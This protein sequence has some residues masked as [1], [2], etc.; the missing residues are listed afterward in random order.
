MGDVGL[1]LIVVVVGDEVFHGVLREKL[2]ELRAEL[3]SQGLVV[4]QHQGWPVHLCDDVGHGE[5]LAGAGDTQEHLLV[6]AVFQAFG[7]GLNGF[8]LISGGLERRVQL[9]Y[10]LQDKPSSPR[11]CQI[12]L[13]LYY[14]IEMS[15]LQ[16][17]PP[18]LI[19]AVFGE[20]GGILSK[21]GKPEKTRGGRLSPAGLF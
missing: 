16:V 18:G 17:F 3:G 4:G 21:P 8:R 2:L 6:Q 10:S 20:T 11:F 9:E 5:G 1:R 12:R 13:I 15:I 14:T 19:P 7:Q